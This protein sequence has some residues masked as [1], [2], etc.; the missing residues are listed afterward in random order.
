M[1]T[2]AEKIQ[3]AC[4]CGH[5]MDSVNPYGRTRKFKHGHNGRI[6]GSDIRRAAR[7]RAFAKK[8]YHQNK[9]RIKSLQDKRR[10]EIREYNRKYSAENPIKMR[11]KAKVRRARLAGAKGHHSHEQWIARFNYFGRSCLYCGC[12][13][14]DETVTK[15][16]QIP[17]SRGG[18]EWPSNL[19]PAC[20][21]CNSK[22]GTSKPNE[23]K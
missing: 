9:E 8:W 14:T 2:Y 19:V 1:K 21:P 10:D 15:D 4:G 20:R 18:S 16:H 23:R 11:H 7:K 3:C 13:L 12:A 5:L 22:K 17:I 6:E